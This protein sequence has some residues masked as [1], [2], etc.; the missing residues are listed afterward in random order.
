M[1]PRQTGV[2]NA[3]LTNIVGTSRLSASFLYRRHFLR[4]PHASAWGYV[5][6]K[7]PQADAWGLCRRYLSTLKILRGQPT[8]PK[9]IAS[10]TLSVMRR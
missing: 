9:L 10:R 6:P 1:G 7:Y 2:L 5:T 8:S 4:Q 3:R